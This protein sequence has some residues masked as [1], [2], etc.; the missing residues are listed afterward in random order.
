MRQRGRGT[1][2]SRA[3]S[4]V[5]ARCRHRSRSRPGGPTAAG[6]AR[7]RARRSAIPPSPATPREPAWSVRPG[8]RAR[9][10]RHE[11]TGLPGRS[12][13]PTPGSKAT[14][15]SPAPS[16][17]AQSLQVPNDTSP[18]NLSDSARPASEPIRRVSPATT[19]GADRAPQPSRRP[20]RR[21]RSTAR[22][23]PGPDPG[24]SRR[25]SASARHVSPP[26]RASGCAPG[27]R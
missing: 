2:R 3:E 27:G 7:R 25:R 16:T 26:R 14:C 11:S 6:T 4:N 1:G 10:L 5:L 21:R 23:V 17:N 24:A 13:H 18:T 20:A 22:T 15:R 12:W 19:Q 9:R 8:R